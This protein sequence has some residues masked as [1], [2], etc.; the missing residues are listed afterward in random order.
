MW[1]LEGESKCGQTELEMIVGGR[2]NE[3]HI[4]EQSLGFGYCAGA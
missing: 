3:F 1:S 4:Q 2:E